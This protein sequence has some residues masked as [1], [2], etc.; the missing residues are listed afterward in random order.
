M[1]KGQ[2]ITNLNNA[3]RLVYLTYDYAASV[4]TIDPQRIAMLEQEIGEHANIILNSLK[5]PS[6]YTPPLAQAVQQPFPVAPA[7]Q[8]RQIGDEEVS[9]MA[10]G[11][12]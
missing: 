7:Q 2:L 4:D 3:V 5:K 6:N 11:D 8:E 10:R 1:D 9:S 12:T